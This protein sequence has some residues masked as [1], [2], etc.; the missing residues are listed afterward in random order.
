MRAGRLDRQLRV[1]RYQS[2][3]TDPDYGTPL[4]GE[5]VP[6][7]T[8]WAQKTHK[9]EDE[10]VAANVLYAERLVTFRT[11]Y[12]ADVVETDRLEFDGLE[13]EVKGIREIGRRIGLEIKAQ[14]FVGG[15]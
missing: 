13:F 7:L 12:T 3:G 8:L 6:V 15:S 4:P 11:R 10:G 14:A 9:S 2:P 1:L 5:W